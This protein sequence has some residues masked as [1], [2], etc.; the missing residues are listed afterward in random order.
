METMADQIYPLRYQ[1]L[2]NLV[3]QVESGKVEQARTG[4]ADLLAGVPGTL[5]RPEDIQI[6]FFAEA[7]RKRLDPDAEE[8]GNLYLKPQDDRQI[9]T[10]NFM[11]E[12]FP[13]VRYS[14]EMLNQAYVQE[15]HGQTQVTILDIGIGTGQQMVRLLE[16]LCQSEPALR[17]VTVIGVEPA[18]QS[19][20]VAE[21]ALTEAAG[22]RGLTFEFV[23][24]AKSAE[25][26]DES[27][28]Q[29]LG[30]R[31]GK[32]NAKLLVNCSFALHHIRPVSLRTTLFTRLKRYAPA[33]LGLIEPYADF[34]IPDLQVRFNHA[35]H[36]YGLV[37]Q[38]IDRIDAPIEEKNRV[39]SFFFRPEISDVLSEEAY[40]VEQFETGEMWV[41]RL[42]QSGFHIA[43][44]RDVMADIP[45]CPFV[46]I[47]RHE[48]YLSLDLEGFP[49]LSIILA[50]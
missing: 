31:L 23:A 12:K 41:S 16:S 5:E 11:A 44:L 40:R 9:Q 48:H 28:W 4:V 38:A 15:C 17:T 34:L 21:S 6:L 47:T 20:R 22:K 25:S 2:K 39:K 24:I 29:D 37:F 33:L 10:F 3:G 35:W 50:R 26:M 30:T 42:R 1:G 13:L 27:D 18:D 8:T 45:N 49:I 32:L 19:L 7:L 14:Q 43:Q 36:H 46:Q